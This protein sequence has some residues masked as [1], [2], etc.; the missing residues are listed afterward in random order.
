MYI[1]FSLFTTKISSTQ[2]SSNLLQVINDILNL[3]PKLLQRSQL[4]SGSTKRILQHLDLLAIKVGQVIKKSS[5]NQQIS[6]GFK[7]VAFVVA[8]KPPNNLHIT[9]SKNLNG[10]LA[11]VMSQNPNSDSHSQPSIAGFYSG[12]NTYRDNQRT[13]V[14]SYLF[15]KSSLFQYD[16]PV[17][18]KQVREFE[19]FLLFFN[20]E[21]TLKLF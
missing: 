2:I 9:S 14:Y 19:V 17:E 16:P 11:L 15:A 7:N 18:K 13:I 8:F 10:T 4:E 21:N 5:M 1:F 3:D 20:V 12:N 6:I